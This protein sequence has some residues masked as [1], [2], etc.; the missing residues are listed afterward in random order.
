[1]SSKVACSFAE[2]A[3]QFRVG[4][5]CPLYCPLPRKEAHGVPWR[6]QPLINT[7]CDSPTGKRARGSRM[8]YRF[9]GEHPPRHLHLYVPRRHCR[10]PLI[11]DPRPRSASP[12][13]KYNTRAKWQQI[14]KLVFPRAGTLFLR[15]LSLGSTLFPVPPYG[16]TRYSFEPSFEYSLWRIDF[17]FRLQIFQDPPRSSKY[18]LNIYHSFSYLE[19]CNELRFEN[20]SKWIEPIVYIISRISCTNPARTN[21]RGNILLS[22]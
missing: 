13:R 7:Q 20:F 9:I 14:T 6:V 18:F 2:R 4:D 22:Y 16:I 12:L 17:R 5:F 11:T 3:V 1:M 8:C 21:T 10:P 19:L 15:K